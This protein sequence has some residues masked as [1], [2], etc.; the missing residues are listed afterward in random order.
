[1]MEYQRRL[2]S[3][4]C[5]QVAMTIK[6][7][8]CFYRINEEVQTLLEEI[9]RIQNNRKHHQHNEQ[10]KEWIVEEVYSTNKLEGLCVQK[11]N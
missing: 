8:P 7:N 3:D 5:R 11:K 4:E 6:G 2:E 10:L 9:H 1:M